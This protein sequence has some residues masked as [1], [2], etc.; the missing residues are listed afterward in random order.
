MT[1]KVNLKQKPRDYWYPAKPIERVSVKAA[2]YDSTSKALGAIGDLITAW[3]KENVKKATTGGKAPEFYS[4]IS[5]Q[6]QQDFRSRDLKFRTTKGGLAKVW[7]E[8]SLDKLRKTSPAFKNLTQKQL[9]AARKYHYRYGKASNP[10]REMIGFMKHSIASGDIQ[11][12][13]TLDEKGNY[14]VEG[15]V[16]EDGEDVKPRKY[17]GAKAYFQGE[18]GIDLPKF[19]NPKDIEK[20]NRNIRLIL[21]GDKVGILLGDDPIGNFPEIENYLYTLTK[22]RK[23]S[24]KDQ[25]ALGRSADKGLRMAQRKENRDYILGRRR[26]NDRLRKSLQAV[27]S[28]ETAKLKELSKDPSVDVR[29]QKR[30]Q[31]EL[32]SRI[33]NMIQEKRQGRTFGMREID[34]AILDIKNPHEQKML[35]NLNKAADAHRIDSVAITQT[36]RDAFGNRYTEQTLYWRTQE[37]ANRIYQHSMKTQP[38]NQDDSQNNPALVAEVMGIQEPFT[39]ERLNDIALTLHRA[40]I[41]HDEFLQSYPPSGNVE[42]RARALKKLIKAIKNEKVFGEDGE[43]YL[44]DYE[45]GSTIDNISDLLTK[46]GYTKPA[47]IE[48]PTQGWGE[49]LKSKAK[50][51]LEKLGG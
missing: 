25:R 42:V 31:R 41:T 7:A 29:L 11:K 28:E 48:T 46:F 13:L 30:S 1:S 6:I 4:Q 17:R 15:F 14:I 5:G 49:W 24:H 10:K 33:A 2:E 43:N 12:G 50:R 39:K 35:R 44:R 21:A 47:K 16:G 51:F 40:G 27:R 36:G 37:L 32:T 45:Q 23:L 22:N 26:E 34:N 8:T 3:D 19:M 9:D 38:L 20:V 18:Y